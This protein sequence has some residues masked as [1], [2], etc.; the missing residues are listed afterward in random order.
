MADPVSFAITTVA[1]VGISYLFPSQGPRLKDTK[2]AAS[3]YGNAIPQIYGTCR[4][5][6]NM[7]WGT[8]LIEHKKK[9]KTGKGGFSEN[10][11]YTISMAFGFATGPIGSFRRIWADGKLIYDAT[12]ASPL[13]SQQKYN[14]TFYLGDE[15]Q[16]PNSTIVAD[17]GDNA[18]AFRGMAYVVFDDFPLIDFSN[19][20][21]QMTAEV[22][23]A[24]DP[25][26]L[27][28]PQTTL[29]VIVGDL[30]ERGGLTSSQYDVTKLATQ[31]VGGYGF[32]RATDIKSI[33]DELRQV[34]LF[35]LV[36]TQGVLRAQFR[37]A[38]AITAGNDGSF[39]G[40]D[41]VEIDH[42]ESVVTC[43]SIGLPDLH[44]F[45]VAGGFADGTLNDHL[46]I[47]QD[48]V[49][50]FRIENPDEVGKFDV[51][52]SVSSVE[53]D[54]AD[55]GM[56]ILF[57]TETG[58]WLCKW[59]F[60]PNTIAWTKQVPIDFSVKGWLKTGQLCSLASFSTGVDGFFQ[61]VYILDTVTGLWVSR[62]DTPAEE[63][64][65]IGVPVPG[66]EHAPLWGTGTSYYDSTRDLL[67]NLGSTHPSVG[68][69][70]IVPSYREIFRPD[71]SNFGTY[72]NGLLQV[73]PVRGQAYVIFLGDPVY[74]DGFYQIDYTKAEMTWIVTDESLGLKDNPDGSG[75]G[76]IFAMLGILNSSGAIVCQNG[77]GNQCQIQILDYETKRSFASGGGSGIGFGAYPPV[78]GGQDD[79]HLTSDQEGNERIIF[80]GVLGDVWTLDFQSPNPTMNIPQAV[81][82]SSSVGGN[83]YWVETRIQDQDLP[84]SISLGYTNSDNDYQE[85]VARSARV[86]NPLPSM[87][88]LQSTQIGLSLTMNAVQAKQQ[89][90]K[91]LYS[92]WAERT[93]H[94]THL[95]WAYMYLDPSDNIQVEMDDGRTF[96]ERVNTMEM[97]A[98]FAF[99]VST[100]GQD[101]GA[102]QTFITTADGGSGGYPTN[103]ITAPVNLQP[104]IVNT[105]L[106]RDVDDT[107]GSF[108]LYYAGMGRLAS[109]TNPFN[110]GT[111]FRAVNGLDYSF[112]F[113]TDTETMWGSVSGVVPTAREGYFSLDWKTK[114][115]ITPHST[116]FEL[117]SISDDELWAGGNPCLIGEEVIQFRDAVENSNGTWTISN[118]LRGRRGTEY[119]IDT[120][121]SG[122]MFLFL[123]PSDLTGQGDTLDARGQSRQ[124]IAVGYGGSSETAEVVEVVYEPRDLMPYAPVY[125]TRTITGSVITAS[126]SRRTRTGG[127]MMDGTGD[128][129]LRET[130]E[131][132]EVYFMESAFTGDL[133]RGNAPSNYLAMFTVNSPTVTWDSAGSSFDPNLDALTIVVYQLSSAVGR[134]F[135]GTRTIL[136][137]DNQ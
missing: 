123:D 120:H 46:T 17:K 64:S 66:T 108:S 137:T 8:G 75:A 32:A 100:Y 127:E 67:I 110:G 82:G 39:T 121:Q 88:S 21:P 51:Q 72:Q 4:V 86:S 49:A 87:Y 89:A 80:K 52:F 42:F 113:G 124:F 81:L 20:I 28:A 92:Q 10:Y 98:D 41:I 61:H 22:S 18:P 71:G 116:Q 35:D 107:N 3:T 1:Q 70:G 96:L 30:L 48:N 19:H 59:L 26:I 33:M 84:A 44:T 111:A 50:M 133:S 79:S 43:G 94:Q 85:S 24:T 73:D 74:N 122:E 15:D 112:L 103:L 115:E 27:P 60:Y 25:S 119:G 11:T 128:V 31:A 69:I 125:I 104:F 55:N 65:Y 114:I 54:Q 118:L 135:P 90:A 134:G 78:G 131:S 126:W 132:Y 99:Q 40:T 106:L 56:L 36:E 53:W 47:Y 23:Y 29:D 5:A 63:S 58:R 16:V 68:E 102:Y 136:P 91:I 37:G 38:G 129:P 105:P 77:F 9:V 13:E 130:A 62:T 95:P 83:D 57:S 101:S 45:Y 7:I 6:G 34:Y 93:T 76:T 117:E 97:G 2:I 14:F 12:G 109:D